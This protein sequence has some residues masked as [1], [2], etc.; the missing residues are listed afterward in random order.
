MHRL[1]IA[2]AGK[3]DPAEGRKDRTMH[4]ELLRPNRDPART[5][6]RLPA[7][8][9]PEAQERRREGRACRLPADWIH[10]GGLRAFRADAGHLGRSIAALKLYLALV[11]SQ[12]AA[13]PAGEPGSILL[14][15]ERIAALS[16]LSDP[17]ICAGKKALVERGLVTTCGERPGGTI[18]YR[19]AGLGPAAGAAHLLHAG[20]DG[21][22]I[23]ALHGLTCRKAPNLAALKTYLLLNACGS[24]PDGV[25]PLD[26]DAAADL[27]Q[28]SHVKILAALAALQG[29]GLVDTLPS[30]AR[31]A[32]RPRLRLLPLR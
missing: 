14:S 12:D 1:G 5:P 6:L 32:E 16:G 13:P 3:A 31:A 28:L 20:P 2:R 23:A 25:V 8:A 26:V 10:D 29:L 9:A 19:L 17:L 4:P 21:A 30:P 11:V 15:Y 27:T 7:I 22:G 24:D 18:A